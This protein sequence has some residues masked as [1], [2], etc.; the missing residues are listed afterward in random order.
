M[1]FQVKEDVYGVHIG[2]TIADA[3]RRPLSDEELKT[4]NLNDLVQEYDAKT[5]KDAPK[6]GGRESKK[7]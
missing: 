2:H 7:R 3:M 1:Y 4:L 5:D 6:K